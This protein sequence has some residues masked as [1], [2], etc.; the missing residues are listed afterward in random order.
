MTANIQA[1]TPVGHIAAEHPRSTR[2]FARLGIDFCCGGGRPLTEACA[3]RG[4]DGAS[5][6]REIETELAREVDASP[7]WNQVDLRELIAHIETTFHRP[8]REEL[9]R[10]EAMAR[11][12][13]AAHGEK[14]PETLDELVR[15]VTGLRAE[16]EDHMQKEEVILFP[17]IRS[18]QGKD[19]GAPVKVMEHE[20][21]EAG[22]AL[23]RIRELTDD[24]TVPEGA[25]TTWRALWDG[26]REL[27]EDMHQHIH[28][29]NN[30][31]FPRALAG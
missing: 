24:Y 20:H 10:L 27:E 9:P 22:D 1:D 2:V 25:C 8:L 4:L 21:E 5:V 18:G 29:E 26:L 14:E 16:L 15:V 13:H 23:R 7:S 31:L 28:L 19:V 6:A 30:V 12:V 11:K 17:L 3:A